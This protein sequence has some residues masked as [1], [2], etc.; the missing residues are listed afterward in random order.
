MTA[1]SD[2]RASSAPDDLRRPSGTAS[3]G[4]YLVVAMLVASVPLA[5]VLAYQTFDS[6]RLQQQRL[7]E[8]LRRS[9]H[10]LAESVERELAS[11]VDVLQAISHNLES[12]DPAALV[13]A[14]SVQ[15]V[16]PARA[17]WR[18][19][20]LLAPD[21]SV[22]FDSSVG[23]ALPLQ[24]PDLRQGTRQDVRQE[25]RQEARQDM[26]P[27][28][29]RV[30]REG[31]DAAVAEPR[32]VATISNLAMLGDRA[33][34]SVRI[35]HRARDGTRYT[36]GAWI[37]AARWQEL[38]VSAGPPESGMMSLFDRDHRLIARSNAPQM[39]GRTLPAASIDWIRRG[40]P[41]V[42]RS[43]L[44]EGGAAY[45]AWA[46][47]D[48]SGWGV[49]AQVPA[50]PLENA[51][52]RAIVTALATTA[53]CLVLGVALAMRV[54]RRV[55]APLHRLAAGQAPEGK[56]LVREIAQLDAALGAAK[57]RELQSRAHL[58]RKA[59]DFQALFAAT[60]IGLAFTT[61]GSDGPG[62]VLHNAAM[63]ALIGPP[64]SG[65]GSSAARSEQGERNERAERAER[66]AD[67]APVQ[68]FH[69]G[70]LLALHEQ[71]LQRAVL[72]GEAVGP[73]ELELRYGSGALRHV[74]SRA[75][76]LT[77]RQ[78]NTRGAVAAMVDITDR[79]RAEHRVLEA[80][81]RLRESQRLIDLAQE[82]GDVG[83]FQF[84]FDSRSGT[85]TPGQ[86]R[87]FGLDAAHLPPSPDE[88]LALVHPQD[89]DDLAERLRQMIASGRERQTFEYRVPAGGCSSEGTGVNDVGDVS[90][91]G[92]ANAGEN[93]GEPQWLSTRVQLSFKP[94][95]RPRHLVGVSLNITE[96]KNAEEARAAL[97]A[98]EQRARLEAESA[99]RAKDEFLAMLGHEL[100][101]PLGA[102]A[103]AV[104]VLDRVQADA[105]VAANARQIIARQTRHL[106]RLMDD[107]L[108][109]G[110]VISGKVR[111]S[112]RSLDLAALVQRVVANFEVT[113]EGRQHE[114][115]LRLNP[116][117]V[118]VDA[119][120]LEQVLTNL[121]GNAF[122]YT[123]P[124]GIVEVLLA[125]K[126][127]HAVLEVRDNGPG[128]PAELMPHIFDLFVQ[129]ER[130]L[131][132][133][134]GGL[135]IGLTLVRRIVELHG[136]EVGV[137]SAATGTTFS[138][139][140]PSTQAPVD[141]PAHPGKR[142]PALRRIV[143]IEDNEDALTAMCSMLELDGH[144]V[145]TAIDGERGL[146]LLL[147]ERPDAAIVD[148]GLP[149]LSG[150]EVARRCRR[151]GYAGRLLALS[152]Y[153][154][155]RSVDEARRHGFDAHLAKPVDP[156]RL[157][158]LLADT[159]EILPMEART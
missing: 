40:L 151:A 53:A 13:Q 131:D 117:W 144:H 104:E 96:H 89:R 26:R 105:P 84:N 48:L 22:L 86:A 1:S 124:G 132:R 63:D 33:G 108:D 148:I 123:E 85:W 58:Q 46:G 79:K 18:S 9:T 142:A 136:G 100:R 19:V 138:V 14:L 157:R 16:Q 39:I 78:G 83:F 62:P 69:H 101:N 57:E 81:D 112:R 94:D 80:D 11:T 52:T 109:V 111:L 70:H 64:H 95:G 87:L 114:L 65:V 103:S 133:R 129:G 59:D 121:L 23:T 77:D 145:S 37:D 149:G 155:G 24:M 71:P 106:A 60:P 49:S 31:A 125:S 110:R 140:L 73:F 44:P 72:R 6:L 36:L 107:L 74:L 147:R 116:A 20:Y 43:D 8:T 27:R 146:A 54:A 5:L 51:R 126:D 122:K 28:T 3:L 127:G 61:L 128:I 130:P 34:T 118:D 90:D 92:A 98:S 152:G 119:T 91:V 4:T 82:A 153:G 99:S 7:N 134:V 141:K 135:G 21:G 66:A 137:T 68:I 150:Y 75:M 159:Q 25:L 120:R 50:A 15:A 42:Q 158:E 102:I 41:G 12:K 47:S 10:A 156:D 154:G 76:P 35:A 93:V 17:P 115:R 56:P 67:K 143:V 88:M 38:V 45:G 32:A 55:T 113:G 139:R 30:N 97:T 2:L 29:N